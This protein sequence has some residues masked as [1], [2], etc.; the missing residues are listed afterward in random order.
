MRIAP[1]GFSSLLRESH[2]VIKLGIIKDKEVVGFCAKEYNLLG[3]L[4]RRLIIIDKDYWNGFSYRKRQ[5]LLW[6]EIGH[7]LFN[8]KHDESFHFDGCPRSIM[9]PTVLSEACIELHYEDYLL[10]LL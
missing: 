10:Q 8:K 3:D 2:L 9:Y 5:L 1:M 6:H 7:C 4:T